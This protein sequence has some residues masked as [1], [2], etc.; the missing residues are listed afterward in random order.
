M[1]RESY[2]WSPITPLS[3]EDRKINLIE[4]DSLASAWRAV[5]KDLKEANPEGLRKFNERLIRSW[6][7]ETGIIERIYDLDQSTTETLIE[8]GFNADLIDR[9]STNLEPEQL[10][11]ILNNHHAA[12]ELVMNGVARQRGLTKGFIFEFHAMLTRHQETVEAVDQFGNRM[13]VP[14]IRGKFKELPNNPTRPDG[15]VHEYCPPVHV[16]SEMENLLR[17]SA[18]YEDK[19]H[20]LIL[21]AWL[22]HRFTQIHPFQDGNGRVARCLVNLTL[23]R[24]LLLP[25]VIPREERAMYIQALERADKGNLKEFIFFLAL[26]EKAASEY[27]SRVRDEATI[28]AMAIALAAI[29]ELQCQLDRAAQSFG[30]EKGGPFIVRVPYSG[31]HGEFTD[32]RIREAATTFGYRVSQSGVGHHLAGKIDFN[33]STDPK[34][35]TE[36]RFELA[37]TPLATESGWTMVATSMAWHI[38]DLCRSPEEWPYPNVTITDIPAMRQPFTITWSDTYE[39]I[40]TPF[41]EWLNE[42]LAIALKEWGDR[43]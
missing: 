5:E 38:H 43:L 36:F 32:R 4:I 14:L 26:R 12:A 15:M 2:K 22:H 30:D 16:D 23:L 9:R 3:D 20:P 41:L 24:G 37:L 25:I 11:T 27:V 29:P 17:L 35:V 19:E 8:H 28:L 13:R 6:S 39:D 33:P 42:C 31:M 1:E 40:L 34:T 18:E 10:V 21:A 7:I